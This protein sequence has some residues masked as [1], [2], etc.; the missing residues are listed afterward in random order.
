MK[1]WSRVRQTP[2][3]IKWLNWEYWPSGAFYYPLVPYFLWLMLK[4]R[5]ICYFT[6]ANPGIYTGGLGLESKYDT[7]LTTP[8]RY[9]PNAILAQPGEDFMSILNRLQEASIVFPLI[10]KPDIG[11]RG[12]LVQKIATAAELEL[13]LLRYPFTFILQEFITLPC[14]IGVF[15]HRLPGQEIGTVSSLT[16]KEFLSVT[17]DGHHTVEQ[18]IGQKDRTILQLPRLLKTHA[19]LMDYVP[20]ISEKVPLGVIGNH[21]KGTRFIN[22]SERI[23]RRIIATF[24][25]ISKEIPGFYYGRFDIK[26]QSFDD[27]YTG[28]NIQII[29]ING[30]CSEPTHIYD[31]EKG[32]YWSAL[33]DIAAQWHLIYQIATANH[34]QGVA[35][36]PTREV[37]D[38]FRRLFA[39]QRQIREIEK[40]MER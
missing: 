10:A 22:S 21:S 35:Y 19:H 40:D 15:Y 24:D 7:I 36:L 8:L 25:Q 5:H 3:V 23:D 33:R 32:S 2:Y 6:A 30:I 9:R 16:T 37:A 39:Y 17:G 18:L 38:A 27:L 26:C 29:E 12:L 14:E 20:G 34:R 13:F 11:F 4:A 28:E 31:A 1:W